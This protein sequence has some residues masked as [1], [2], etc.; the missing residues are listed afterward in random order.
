M[1]DEKVRTTPPMPPHKPE[2][3]KE[4]P[5]K[6]LEEV[7]PMQPTAKTTEAVGRAVTPPVKKEKVY[8]SKELLAQA[9]EVLNEYGGKETNIPLTSPYWALMNDYRAELRK[10]QDNA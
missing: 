6:P 8:K 2:E 5:I 7:R 1:T 3:K 9:V 10:E 4:E